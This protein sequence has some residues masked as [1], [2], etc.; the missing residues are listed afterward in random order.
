MIKLEDAATKAEPAHYSEAPA[1]DLRSTAV[2][3]RRSSLF[4]AELEWAIDIIARERVYRAMLAR[5]RLSLLAPPLA[6]EED[7]ATSG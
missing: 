4:N 1:A 5:L 3:V 2:V 6:I 7:D